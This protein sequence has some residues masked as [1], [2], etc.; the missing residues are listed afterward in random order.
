MSP[1]K[2]S[3]SGDLN[4]VDDLCQQVS[5]LKLTVDGLERERDFYYGKL[6]DIEV[7]CQEEEQSNE[8]SPL[9]DKILDVLYATEEG[10]AVPDD[11]LE[12]GVIIPQNNEDEEY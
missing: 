8:K 3:G 12:D 2:M 10:F 1:N 5:E 9:V 7:I 4:R 11:A 6:R